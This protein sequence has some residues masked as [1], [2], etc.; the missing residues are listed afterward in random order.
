MFNKWIVSHRTGTGCVLE[1]RPHREYACI[2]IH[3]HKRCVGYTGPE[4]FNVP[5]GHFQ[6]GPGSGRRSYQLRA[7]LSLIAC[8]PRCAL[9]SDCGRAKHAP[10]RFVCKVVRLVKPDAFNLCVLACCLADEIE[11]CG[12]SAVHNAGM[13]YEQAL[14]ERVMG[15]LVHGNSPYQRLIG[16]GF[17]RPYAVHGYQADL[18]GT[19][20]MRGMWS[21]SGAGTSCEPCYSTASRLWTRFS[22][23]RGGMVLGAYANPGYVHQ[24]GCTMFGQAAIL[25]VASRLGNLAGGIF[26]R[27]GCPSRLLVS[28]SAFG[29]RNRNEYVVAALL[30]AAYQ[31]GDVVGNW[32]GGFGAAHVANSYLHDP[33]AFQKVAEVCPW[34]RCVAYTAMCSLVIGAGIPF[35]PDQVVELDGR[36]FTAQSVLEGRGAWEIYEIWALRCSSRWLGVGRDLCL[37]AVVRGEHLT[38]CPNNSLQSRQM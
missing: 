35:C 33:I 6:V 38:I 28:R 17:S 32:V 34:W 20:L 27:D 9:G 15:S 11:H 13:V 26:G 3:P 12:S 19:F 8:C 10:I 25:S 31:M 22:W 14:E 30:Q 23:A 24:D 29:V 2:Q 1:C 5:D 37:E 4:T 16:G 21:Q 18:I 7:L 36:I